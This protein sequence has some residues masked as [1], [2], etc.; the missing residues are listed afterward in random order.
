MTKNDI[1]FEDGYANK[2]FSFQIHQ[3]KDKQNNKYLFTLFTFFPPIF[4]QKESSVEYRFL[5]NS[6]SLMKAKETFNNNGVVL[7]ELP[8]TEGFYFPRFNNELL[9][10][11]FMNSQE[12]K[13][14]YQERLNE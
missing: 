11:K 7:E 10:F 13:K 8:Y 4:S 9:A 5:A 6:L 1:V 2:D 14:T 3:G 12:F